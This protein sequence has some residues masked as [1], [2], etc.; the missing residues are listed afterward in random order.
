MARLQQTVNAKIGQVVGKYGSS[1]H[2]QSL[3][4]SGVAKSSTAWKTTS[5]PNADDSKPQLH[6]HMCLTNAWP[7]SMSM[8]VTCIS[9]LLD[10]AVHEQL[11]RC[12]CLGM[13]HLNLVLSLKNEKSYSPASALEGPLQ[14]VQ[15]GGSPSLSAWLGAEPCRPRPP[16][17]GPP[18]T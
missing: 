8:S 5:R 2:S 12:L 14:S 9:F 13:C 16:A 17:P 7:W 15:S 11:S 4:S 18:L 3:L 10:D 6:V 1:S